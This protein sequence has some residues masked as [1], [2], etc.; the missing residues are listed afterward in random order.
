MCD[1]HMP[2]TYTPFQD[3]YNEEDAR[4]LQP[5]KQLHNDSNCCKRMWYILWFISIYYHTLFN[6]ASVSKITD[7][8]SMFFFVVFIVNR[9]QVHQGADC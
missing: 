1:L 2:I 7:K 8:G 5:L 4:T 9:T 6:M 3:T